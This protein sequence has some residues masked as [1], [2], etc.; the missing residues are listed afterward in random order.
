MSAIFI[1]LFQNNSTAKLY[2]PDQKRANFIPITRFNLPNR[3][4][5]LA[6]GLKRLPESDLCLACK[7][8]QDFVWQSIHVLARLNRA[9]RINSFIETGPK[10]WKGIAKQLRL[11]LWI[12]VRYLTNIV[13]VA[14]HAPT[15]Y[16]KYCMSKLKDC[17][18]SS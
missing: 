18:S 9:R 14:A 6:A 15:V 13:G 1:F 7:Q 4:V 16:D 8:Q 2:L 5:E 12:Q 3:K 11:G 10:F 17:Q